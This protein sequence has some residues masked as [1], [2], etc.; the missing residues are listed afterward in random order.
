M[1]KLI[2]FAFLFASVAASAQESDL[3]ANKN[4][5]WQNITTLNINCKQDKE[6]VSIHGA[7][8]FSMLRLTLL[9][10]PQFIQ[11]L[12]VYFDNNTKQVIELKRVMEHEYSTKNIDLMGAEKGIKKGIKKM[13]LVHKINTNPNHE[14]S[15]IEIWGYKVG[16]TP[17]IAVQEVPVLLIADKAGWQKIGEQTIDR[18]IDHDEIQVGGNDSFS[19]LKF[20]AVF[21]SIEIKNAQ[22]YFENGDNQSIRVQSPLI[23]GAESTVVDLKVPEQKIKKIV[24]EYNTLPDQSFDKGL[25]EVWGY[26]MN[27]GKD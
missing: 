25:V 4:S 6:T 5:T 8:K 22:V 20:M 23:T 10:D 16:E 14:N 12:E 27:A 2:H 13:V 24:F 11:C 17:V 3:H 19:S 26:K 18:E 15:S 21:A 1:K 9:G 7:N